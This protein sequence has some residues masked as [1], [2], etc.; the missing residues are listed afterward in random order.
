MRLLRNLR[1]LVMTGIGKEHATFPLPLKKSC[2]CEDER[3]KAS[4][5][6]EQANCIIQVIE[7]YKSIF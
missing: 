3:S 5:D 2:H 7:G 1:L 6:S 4:S